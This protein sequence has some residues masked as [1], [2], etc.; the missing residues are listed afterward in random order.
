MLS[1]YVLLVLLTV[2][3]GAPSAAVTIDMPD[4]ATCE[5]VAL[6]FPQDQQNGAVCVDRRPE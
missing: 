2:R 3:G 6:E 5:R 1:P 4:R